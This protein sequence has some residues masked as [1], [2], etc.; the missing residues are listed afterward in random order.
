MKNWLSFSNTNYVST[1]IK[2]FCIK[3][4]NKL[5]LN[6]LVLE[7]PKKYA[8]RFFLISA[9]YFFSLLLFNSVSFLQ[10]ICCYLFFVLFYITFFVFFAL[11]CIPLLLRSIE[12]KDSL[13]EKRERDKGAIS[14][15]NF[16]ARNIMVPIIISLVYLTYYTGKA[17]KEKVYVSV[18]RQLGVRSP[19]QCR[20]GARACVCVAVS[21]NLT[22]A[23]QCIL[24]ATADFFVFFFQKLRQISTI[25]IL[26]F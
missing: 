10:N 3:H 6:K 23:I 5:Q 21:V 13:N 9:F 16:L 8:L 7:P 25:G 14:L 1:N 15:L 18:L 4:T 24:L 12:Q 17:S 19:V 22:L 2:V 11:I 20:A 26:F